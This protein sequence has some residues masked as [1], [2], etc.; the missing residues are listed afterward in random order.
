MAVARTTGG[1]LHE[2]PLFTVEPLLVLQQDPSTPE[3][4][5]FQP[6]AF[7]PGPDGNYYIIDQGSG[8]V[9]V[10]DDTGV[11]IRAFG[12]KG[13]GPGEFRMMELQSLW[14]GVLSI[15]DYSQQRTIWFRTDGSLLEVIR[16]PIGGYALSLDRTPSGTILQG[17]VRGDQDGP[18][19]STERRMTL[20]SGTG[21]DTLAVIRTGLVAE[22]LQNVQ[23]LPNGSMVMIGKPLAYSGSPR[24]MYHP[25]YGILATDG[26]RPELIWYDTTGQPRLHI[27]ID[28]PVQPTT[29]EMKQIYRE[30]ERAEAE[31]STS[32]SGRPSQLPTD[33]PWPDTIGFWRRVT[34]DD[35]GWIWCLDVASLEQHVD[36]ELFLWHVIDREGRYIGTTGLPTASPRIAAGKVMCLIEDQDTGEIAASVFTLRPAVD[37]LIYP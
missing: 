15:F 35:Q 31:E 2:G 6:G 1:P 9:V 27:W 11:F 30:K 21:R 23:T 10:F 8:R 36:G 22:T 3:S 25:G 14:E 12:R 5:L 19:G 17:G 4:L 29:S 16:S 24:V 18:I 26:D 28:L 37:E 7:L 13:E 34:V 20:A 33:Y 32:R